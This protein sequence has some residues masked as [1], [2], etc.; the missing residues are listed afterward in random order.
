MLP[1]NSLKAY[2]TNN[3]DRN[4]VLIYLALKEKKW[5]LLVI[6]E[7]IKKFDDFWESVKDTKA[8]NFKDGE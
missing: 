6:Q 2:M 1:S 3:K 8:T 5:P 7:L 4:G